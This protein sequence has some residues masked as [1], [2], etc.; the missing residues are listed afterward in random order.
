MTAMPLPR[1]VI[2]GASGFIGRHLLESLKE[3]YRI[4]GMARRSQAQCGAPFHDNI[5]W[6]QVDIGDR[7][8]L[9]RAFE[10]IRADG[11]ADILIHLAAHYDFTGENH[12]EYWRTNVEG[13]RNVLEECR[14]LGLRKFVFASS[15]A[16][17]Q[18]PPPGETLT[19]QSPADGDHVYAVTKRIGED[20]LYEFRDVPSCIVR[21]A[22]LFSDWCE[23]P[24]LYFFLETWL[25]SAWN[26]RILGGKG[27]SAIP[28]LHVR[29]LGSFFR[30]LLANVD[31]LSPR[32]VVIASTT[33][34]ASHEELFR[35][36]TLHEYGS[37]RKPVHMPTALARIG[38]V[39]L[40]LVG[41]L[42]GKRPFERPW[43]MRYVDRDLA[44]DPSSTYER[45][46]WQ[47]RERLLITRRMPFLLENRKRDPGEWHRANRAAMKE[48]RIR[49]NLR[50][51]RLLEKHHDEIRD[52]FAAA[53]LADSERFPTYQGVNPD[54]MSWRFTIVLRHLLNAVR[55]G[56]RG[57]FTGYCRDLASKRHE[58]GF[59]AGELCGAL[60]VLETACVETLLAD[61][62]AEGLREPLQ[63]LLTMTIQ[64][65]C[66]QVMETYEELEG[67]LYGE[68]A[69]P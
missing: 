17:C 62:E 40:D 41:R 3:R 21:F 38:V 1:L 57:L 16:A 55:T 59:G 30:R 11:G 6:V 28:Y 24:P 67:E 8:P 66:D 36:A 20:M 63:R 12:P 9:S 35:L 2:T 18:F 48:V 15:V 39:A 26:A 47:P 23:Y 54:I 65:G 14:G 68:P 31:E 49:A 45:L 32:E 5:A 51:H 25:S 43:M 29:D 10:A 19:E 52:R 56:D 44:V 60:D 69:S 7:E 64:F 46:G 53:I 13:L 58:Q 42:L 34:T 4:V 50:I 61:D 27:Q 33:S 37:P 22:A